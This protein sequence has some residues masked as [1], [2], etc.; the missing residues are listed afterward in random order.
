MKQ[1][2]LLIS[3]FYLGCIAAFSQEPFVS[4]YVRYYSTEKYLTF[5]SPKETKELSPFTPLPDSTLPV[6]LS[7]TFVLLS[8]EVSKAQLLQQVVSLNEDFSN[9]TFEK[10]EHKSAYYHKLAVDTQIRFCEN[11]QVIEAYKDEKL[12]LSVSQEYAR[13]FNQTNKNSLLVFVTDFEN[14]AGYAQ[15]PGY[16]SE[17]DA[18]FID[19]RYLIGTATKG[20]DLGK[21]LTHLIGSFLGLGELWNCQ[22]DGIMDTPLMS[23]EHFMKESGWSSCY[24]YVVQTMPE[25]F[26]YNTEDKYLNMF[27]LGQKERMQQVLASEKAHLLEST[28][29]KQTAP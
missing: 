28:T 15:T 17:T 22:D 4:P 21:T 12:D 23:A 16:D 9:Q 7:L 18:I 3:T 8:E 27:T 5:L 6:T 14:I 2:L 11:F 19:K 26:M 29:C 13:K 10:S 25:N 24:S 20:F 1:T